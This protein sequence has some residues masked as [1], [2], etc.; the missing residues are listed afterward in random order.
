MAEPFI[1][2]IKMFA[3]NFAPRGF[4]FCNGQLLQISQNTALFSIIGTIYGGDGRTTTGLP[5]LGGRAALHAGHGP[6]LTDRRLGAKSGVTE[7]A[8]TNA[9]QLGA[10]SHG[11]HASSF[12]GPLNDPSGNTLAQNSAGAPQYAGAADVDMNSS[13]ILPSGSDSPQAHNNRQPYLVL[14]FIIALTGI[15]PSRN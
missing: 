5:D 12:D 14:N 7:V 15:F 1:A 6:G 11:L 13:A 8:L 10:H 2:E 4:A 9:N 3:G